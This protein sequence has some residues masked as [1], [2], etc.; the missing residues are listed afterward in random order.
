MSCRPTALEDG[1]FR[2]RAEGPV[3]LVDKAGP[4][5]ALITRPGLEVAV[6]HLPQGGEAFLTQL[7]AGTPLGGRL[8]FGAGLEARGG[9]F[10]DLSLTGTRLTAGAASY[11][12]RIGGFR[13]PGCS[14]S[15]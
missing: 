3:S 15:R 13:L 12:T 10:L 4:E 1:R 9:Q 11:S 14:A 6:R 8:E 2:A 7:I 5:D